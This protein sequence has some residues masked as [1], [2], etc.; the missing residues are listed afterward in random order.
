MS[1]KCP[2]ACLCWTGDE[3]KN[4][5]KPRTPGARSHWG[6]TLTRQFQTVEVVLTSD[7]V[8]G[9]PRSVPGFFVAEFPFCPH[10]LSLGLQGDNLVNCEEGKNLETRLALFKEREE[11]GLQ[12]KPARCKCKQIMSHSINSRKVRKLSRTPYT[13]THSLVCTHTHTHSR[14]NRVILYL[15]RMFAAFFNRHV[16]KKKDFFWILLIC[17][18]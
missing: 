4:R 6:H 18:N 15:K 7:C 5:R 9:A 2:G 16:P 1:R 14:V 11:N 8:S 17:C 3:K 13:S 10:Y 12:L